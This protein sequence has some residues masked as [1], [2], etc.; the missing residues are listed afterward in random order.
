MRVTCPGCGVLFSF[1]PGPSS[2]PVVCPSC[3]RFICDWPGDATR[4]G[5]AHLGHLFARDEGI[6]LNEAFNGRVAD[7]SEAE[8]RL[9]QWR[10]EMPEVPSSYT[11]SGALPA[12]ALGRML[13]GSLLGGVV[14]FLAGLAAV[15]AGGAFGALV[16]FFLG[17][18]YHVRGDS[19]WYCVVICGILTWICAASWISAACT[20]RSGQLGKNRN[21]PMAALLSV[22]SNLLAVFL[23]VMLYFTMVKPIL[24]Q[25]RWDDDLL[26]YIVGILAVIGTCC[27]PIIAAQQVRAAKFCED[28]QCPMVAARLKTLCLGGLR[29]MV[30]ALAQARLDVAGSLLQGGLK[31]G[32]GEVNLFSCPSCS[33]GYLEVTANYKA[34]WRDWKMSP[35]ETGLSWLV[36]SREL[37][38]A[39]VIQLREKLT[40]PR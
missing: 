22:V 15:P 27:T 4:S 37:T 5:P 36:A 16:W 6:D 24:A 11:P 30:R 12:R 26:V 31:G 39:E 13:A 29:T 18:L 34:E 35:R 20:T 8:T 2:K 33:R 9:A 40:G 17:S 23:A 3:R 14:G 21:V 19:F 38:A 25:R 1:D 7:R 10:R 28:C 32:D